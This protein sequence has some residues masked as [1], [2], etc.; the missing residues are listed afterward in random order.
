MATF[1]FPRIAVIIPALNEQ[2]ALPKVLADLPAEARRRVIVV[3]NGSVDATAEVARAAGAV[4]VSESERGYGAAMHR[5]L[6]EMRARWPETEIVV[7]LDADY[8]DHPEK[9]LEL[10]EPI[11]SGTADFVLGSRSLGEHQP[12]ALMPH[13]RWGN[14][15]ACALVWLRTG[16]YFTDLGPFRAI[17]RRALDSL[18]MVDRDFGWTVEMQIKAALR[19]LRI[20]EIPVPY[21]CRIGTSK[22]SGTLKGSL[23]AGYKILWTIARYGLSTSASFGAPRHALPGA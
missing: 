6:A 9:L 11:R 23:A 16:V 14:R 15:L 5:G 2:E 20:H 3:D 8:S 10:L 22:I 13:A 1:S 19:D 18:E 17:R 21:R 4:V 7:F 12:G